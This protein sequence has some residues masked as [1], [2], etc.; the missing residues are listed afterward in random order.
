MVDSGR[1]R[2]WP[3]Y[4]HQN[5]TSW[6][7]ARAR[8]RR[9]RLCRSTHFARCSAVHPGL[10]HEVSGHL[11]SLRRHHVDLWATITGIHLGLL[12]VNAATVILIFSLGRRLANS[13]VG[14]VAGV[15]YAV[16]SVSPSVLGFAGHATH[17]VLLPVLGGI[18]LL[19]LE[20]TNRQAFGSL[21]ASGMLFG[22]GVLMKQPAVFFALFGAIY[23]VTNNLCH[24]VR[25]EK[26]L[27]RTLIFSAGA[28]LPLGLAC[29][30]FWRIGVLDRFWF[31]TIDY[32]Q[33]Y[34][35]LVP[36]SQAPGF[37]FY[38]AREVIVAGW[39]VWMLAGVGL[40]MGLWGR[41]TRPMAVFL[42]AFFF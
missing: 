32:A 12:L 17:F 1:N 40:V 15:S 35:S 30:L 7:S 34:G 31:W 33:Q 38:S 14:L 23:L 3:R 18:L 10:Q 9:I 36:F 42:L 2:F 29:L 28:I 4:C 8:R 24:R 11:C 41:R 39:P 22:L 6:S 5:S 21:F 16:L 13:V 25:L 26:I 19:L 27:L 37:F 20:G